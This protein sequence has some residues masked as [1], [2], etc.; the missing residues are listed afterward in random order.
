MSRLLHSLAAAAIIGGIG[1]TASAE[2]TFIINIDDASH[3]KYQTG[4]TSWSYVEYPLQNGDN[5]ITQTGSEDFVITPRE[6]YL[7]DTVTAYEEDGTE[8][9]PHGWR[10]DSNDDSY[11]IYFLGSNK[12]AAKYVFT[13]KVDDSPVYTLTIALDNPAAV[14]NGKYTVGNQTITAAEGAQTITFN[15]NKGKNL[16]IKFRALAETVTF[17]RNGQ[18]VQ[19]SSTSNGVRTFKFEL[20]ENDNISVTTQ[21]KDPEYF[22]IIDDP[23]HIEAYCPELLE[24]LSAGENRLLFNSGDRLTI[25]A[26]SGYRIPEIDNMRYN[27]SSEQ[28]TYDFSDNDAGVRF[29]IVTEE[30][31][32]PTANVVLNLDNLNIVNY[33]GIG[34]NEWDFVL[35]DNAYE[36]RTDRVS[37]VTLYYKSR[38]DDKTIATLNGEPLEI[39]PSL[40]DS[41]SSVIPVEENGNYRI[42]VRELLEGDYTGEYT[43]T[44]SESGK[45]WTVSFNPAGII[46]LAD[47]QATA[48]IESLAHSAVVLNEND[49]KISFD[50]D[51]TAGDHILTIP[52]G[53]FSINGASSPAITH[54]FSLV[55][56]GV[57]AVSA[58]SMVNVY[59]IDGRVIL[60]NADRRA[61][62]G[63]DKGIYIIN[64]KKVVR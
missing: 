58:D 56:T 18:T 47:E 55:D 64:G 53:M 57:D 31:N 32:P 62:E 37:N 17:I 8:R 7:I 16:E 45:E 25:K 6:G 22:L 41:Y 42:V 24:G 14:V 11:S 20:G 15:P 23:S 29:N 35:G 27:E 9:T 50:D 39:I 48:N 40:W 28:Y 19:P 33:I 36:V 13:T 4:Q 21:M 1:L 34:S 44:S 60:K 54:N 2:N 38:Y 46:T 26:K 30:F 52:A 51:L 3:V 63:L 12:P 59:S 61:I 43:V 10:F 49:V 5:V